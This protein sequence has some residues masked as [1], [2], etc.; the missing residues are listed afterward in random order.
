[1]WNGNVLI[2]SNRLFSFDI[3]QSVQKMKN[4]GIHRQQGDLISFFYF[5]KN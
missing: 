3:T 1:M 2:I 4:L 5:L